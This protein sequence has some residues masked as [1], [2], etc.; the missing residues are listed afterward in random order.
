MLTHEGQKEAMMARMWYGVQQV[1]NAPRIKD[2]VFNA[3]LARF[4]V[5][6]FSF[7][8]FLNRILLPILLM[9]SC[10]SVGDVAESWTLA[11]PAPELVLLNDLFTFVTMLISFSLF[12]FWSRVFMQDSVSSLLHLLAGGLGHETASPDTVL[13]LPSVSLS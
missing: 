13:P 5:F 4:S 12:C 6:N 8:F 7:F 2:M 1:T 3:F 11:A 9:R 10:L